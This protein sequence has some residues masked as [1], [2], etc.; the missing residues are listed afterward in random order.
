MAAAAAA[1]QHSTTAAQLMN[2]QMMASLAASWQQQQ[3][4]NAAALNPLAGLTAMQQQQMAM[5]LV[6]VLSSTIYNLNINAGGGVCWQWRRWHEQWYN[7]RF[8]PEQHPKR[9]VAHRLATT[10]IRKSHAET[11]EQV[12][13]RNSAGRSLFCW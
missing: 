6:G 2:N 12:E 5:L 9:D 8:T 10:T 4:R 3:Q 13:L 1:L 7:A 11:G